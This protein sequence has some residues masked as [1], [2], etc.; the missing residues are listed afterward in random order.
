MVGRVLSRSG[1]V[2]EGDVE[3]EGRL[4]PAV[5]EH[6]TFRSACS[7]ADPCAEGTSTH[8]C[9][10][11]ASPTPCT[12]LCESAN[13]NAGLGLLMGNAVG[14]LRYRITNG[15]LGLALRSRPDYDL[16]LR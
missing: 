11:A 2:L 5:M 13:E 14:S 7:H 8:A 16:A 12:S 4:V 15:D 1:W 6:G 10:A 3:A 9:P